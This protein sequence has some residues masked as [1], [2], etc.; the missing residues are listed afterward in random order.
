MN[1]MLNTSPRTLPSP[2]GLLARALFGLLI[3]CA[4]CLTGVS[5]R[6]QAVA[7]TDSAPPRKYVPQEM[8]AQLSASKNL[9][10]RLKLALLL[11]DQRISQAAQHTA[12]E[13]YSEAGNE[14][15]IY[16]ALIEDTIN[17]IQRSSKD[18]GRDLFKRLEMTLRSH[19]PRLETI[20]RVTPSDEAV[21]IRACI[22]F[23]RDA[24]TR[25]LE[26][27]YGDTVLRMPKEEKEKKEDLKEGS[28]QTDPRSP[29]EKKPDQD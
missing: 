19:V 16:Q 21:H 13:R 18:K 5:V 2:A 4:G 10:D 17:A 11:A 3:V 15:G 14:L 24:R 27:F 29:S 20:R 12:A 22:E 9:K 8:R 25:A 7:Q 1:D 6:A 28:A 23:V 26:S